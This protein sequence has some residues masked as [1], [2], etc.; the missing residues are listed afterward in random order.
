VGGVEAKITR[1]LCPLSERPPLGRESAGKRR[2]ELP[3]RNKWAASVLGL[4]IEA[5]AEEEE[6]GARSR[7]E[8]TLPLVADIP[9]YWN[10]SVIASTISFGDVRIE[11]S[12]K[13]SDCSFSKFQ[14]CFCLIIVNMKAK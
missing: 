6:D 8:R 7:P 4:S 3:A 12:Q 11:E 1:D 5:A 13:S 9:P 14:H 10:L 2:L